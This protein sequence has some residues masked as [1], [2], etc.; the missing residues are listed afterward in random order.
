MKV[1]I[2]GITNIKDALIASD[3]GADALGFIF[4]K[5]SKR[6]IEYD[7]AKTIITYLPP[8]VLKVGVF[9]NEDYEI[10]N[11]VVGDIGLTNIQLHGEEP[12]EFIN[13]IELPVWKA[14]KINSEFDFKILDSYKNCTF[15]FDTYSKDE[16]GGTGKTFN[17]D[18]IPGSIRNKIIL[19]GG[20]SS[21]NIEKIYNEISPAWVDVSSSLEKAPGKKDDNKL[22]VFFGLI[23]KLR[24]NE[25]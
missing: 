4:Y 2:C 3:L 6:F 8:A 14:F 24:N 23:N 15:M 25:C 12:P 1:K 7:K 21:N 5:K 13:K 17:W 16:H 19:A 22:K 20:I 11:R 18:V 10:I 9:V